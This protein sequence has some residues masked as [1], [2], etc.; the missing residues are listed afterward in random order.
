MEL[1]RSEAAAFMP[2][3]SKN[4]SFWNL[5]AA[6]AL[7]DVEGMDAEAIARKSMRIAGDLCVYTNNSNIIEVM[8]KKD[9][10][11]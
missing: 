6:K 7:I 9:V 10:S 5:A 8:E 1:W 3:V 2:T 11:K 4:P